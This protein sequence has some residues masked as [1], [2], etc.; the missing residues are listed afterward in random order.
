M[1]H[2]SEVDEQAFRSPSFSSHFD[3]FKR[4]SYYSPHQCYVW[5][6]Y[7][8]SSTVSKEYVFLVGVEAFAGLGL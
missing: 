1:E 2:I 8:C 3:D 6:N 5:F 4:F 7:H